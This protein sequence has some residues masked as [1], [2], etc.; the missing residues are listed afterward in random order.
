MYHELLGKPFS[1]KD[2]KLCLARKVAKRLLAEAQEALPYEYSALLTGRGTTITGFLPMPS[3]PDMHAFSWDGAAFLRALHEIRQAGVEW[4]GVLHTH[5]HSP[6]VP[7]ASDRS[8]WHY[9]TLSYWILGLASATPEWRA[10]QWTD[11]AF[12]E[13][14][15]A[16][17]DVT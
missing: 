10:Y 12:I 5:P 6:P 2:T 14:P 17:I 11:G 9:P 13:R 1:F 7:S 8:G 15:Y 3:A 4:L 16:I